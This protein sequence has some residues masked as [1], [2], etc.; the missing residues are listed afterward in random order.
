MARGLK[1]L[2]SMKRS[3]LVALCLLL[4]ACRGEPVPRDY[5]NAP[6]DMGNAATTKSDTP[7]GHGMGEPGRETSTGGEAMTPND[8][9][10]APASSTGAPTT[11]IADT[12]PVTTTTP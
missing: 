5:Q 8:Q 6:P 12:P 10:V 4:G 2:S 9:P 11:T 1:R 3:L 7:A